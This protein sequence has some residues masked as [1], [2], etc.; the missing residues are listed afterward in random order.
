MIEKKILIGGLDTDTSD[1]LIANGDYR[2]ALNVRNGITED[3]DEGELTNVKGN[4]EI[5]YAGYPSGSNITVGYFFDYGTNKGYYFNYNDLGEHHILEYNHTTQTVE[6]VL[7]TQLLNFNPD[8]LITGINV[9]QGLLYWTDDY[10]PPR[11]INIEKAKNINKRVYFSDNFFLTGGKV[12]FLCPDPGTLAVGDFIKIVQNGTPV[13]PQY[14]IHTEI[15]QISTQG[16]NTLIHTTIDWAQSS[17][18]NPGYIYLEKSYILPFLEEYMHEIKFPYTSDIKSEYIS[19]GGYDQNNLRG[20]IY[21]FS[22][23]NVF[24]DGE[25]S[26][27]SPICPPPLPI[28]DQ[29]M[30]ASVDYPVSIQNGIKLQIPTGSDIVTKINVM[31]RK[32][33]AAPFQL[34][35][36]V[37]KKDLKL[38]N[39]SFYEYVFYNNSAPLPVDTNT[40][41]KLFDKVPLLAKAQDI[42]N[43][44]RLVY[45]NILEDYDNVDIRVDMSTYE[46]QVAEAKNPFIIVNENYNLVSQQKY[47]VLKYVI[48]A[49]FT[50]NQIYTFS[51]FA[52]NTLNEKE[53]KISYVSK[54]SDTEQ[55]VYSALASLINSYFQGNPGNIFTTTQSVTA[56]VGTVNPPYGT[57]GTKCLELQISWNEPPIGS[58]DVKPTTKQSLTGY[59]VSQ[60]YPTLK[61]NSWFQYGIVYYDYANRSGATNI[62]PGSK[63]YV[64]YT[65]NTT[66]SPYYS[67]AIMRIYNLPPSWSTHYQIVRT[68]N[69]SI[70]RYLYIKAGNISVS[71]TNTKIYLDYITTFDTNYPDSRLSYTY[72]PGDRIRIH[73]SDLQGAW[74]DL[75]V[76]GQNT[77]SNYI[78]VKTN[79]VVINTNDIIELYTPEKTYDADKQLYYEIGEVHPIILD[80]SGKKI[81]GRSSSAPTPPGNGPLGSFIFQQSQNPNTYTELLLRDWS[82]YL[83]TRGTDTQYLESSSFNDLYASDVDCIGRPNIVSNNIKQQRRPTTSYYSE[84]YVQDTEINGL[85]TFFDSNFE[86]YD[87]KYGSIQKV[88]YKDNRLIMF[89]ENKVANIPV[90]QSIFSSTSGSTTLGLSDQVLS[91]I[92]YWYDFEGGISLNPESFANYG[93]NIYFVDVRR[94]VVCRLAN[95]GIN[96]ISEYKMHNYFTDKCAKL[97]ATGVVRILGVYDRRFANYVVSFGAVSGHR[98]AYNPEN[99][100]LDGSTGG[101]PVSY[102]VEIDTQNALYILNPTVNYPEFRNLQEN[103]ETIAF[104]EETN[105]W[106]S[107][108]S[109]FPEFMGRAGTDIVT[110]KE[111]KIYLHNQTSIYNNYYGV[112][113]PTEVH[114][115]TNEN[116]SNVKVWESVSLEST[117]AWEMN[118]AVTPHNQ[119]TSIALTDFENKENIFYAHMRNDINTPNVVDPII[120]GDV[121]RDVTMLAKFRNASQNFVKIFAINFQ[122][123]ISNLHNR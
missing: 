53:V 75:E 106:I 20:T 5:L 36:A 14:D 1:K 97:M 98:L 119:E 10:N 84:P 28:A 70:S 25:T 16:G 45:T 11:K 67:R 76:V 116:P 42:V 74:Y 60:L 100:V 63:L 105:R 19:D 94:G 91:P 79:G 121:M 57:V 58:A 27:L 93:N 12:G 85:S 69:L 102:S 82:D 50:Y 32:G 104:N 78:E 92:P 62:T 90:N 2:Y 8:F 96:P 110:F 7:Q 81:H 48:T 61:K 80:N 113:W 6:L 41:N 59:G 13:N 9:Y 108:Y 47:S 24:D 51:L 52:G 77:G 21:Q 35:D 101:L 118:Q 122:Y 4:V 99:S 87:T 95:D 86:T 26:S 112:S 107:F 33:N 44:N 111:G 64:G 22:I 115:V 40:Q 29:Q 117:E 46:T 73:G 114:V 109:Y 120:N 49:D 89:F 68:R 55:D 66:Q 65:T 34:I 31:A 71:G 3:S 39:N 83:R 54:T 23:Q 17:P 88:F 18:A 30:Y 123:I 72:T 103:P 56:I 43:G 38:T 37:V 15:T